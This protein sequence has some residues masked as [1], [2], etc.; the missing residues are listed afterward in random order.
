MTIKNRKVFKMKFRRVVMF[1]YISLVGI[2]PVTIFAQPFV[3]LGAGTA[4][5]ADDSE[6]L[7]E[8]T[9]LIW[10]ICDFGQRWGGQY[11]TDGD[12]PAPAEGYIY[13]HEEALENARRARTTTKAWRL[14][15]IKELSSI[16]DWQGSELASIAPAFGVKNIFFWY[17]SSTPNV[18]DP[19]LVGS[20]SFRPGSVSMQSRRSDKG[21]ILLVR[22]SDELM[23]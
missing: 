23:K 11:C 1:L 20:V 2:A 15:N 4:D 5:R 8:A 14:P 18:G 13:T 12:T 9:G 3:N 22:E 16:L 6:L 21:S 17:W 10:R 19:S 7:D